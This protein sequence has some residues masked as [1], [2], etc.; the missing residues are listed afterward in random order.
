VSD[1]SE[2]L[3]VTVTIIWQLQKLGS[4]CQRANEW[5]RRWIW[6]CNLKQLNE[7]EDREQYQVTIKNKS[8]A[9]ENFR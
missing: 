6:S 9:L 2:G 8:A 7:E 1:L 4:D 5:L 3:I